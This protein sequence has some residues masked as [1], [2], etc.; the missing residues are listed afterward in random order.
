M[1]AE[2][3]SAILGISPGT[4]V[5]GL[6]IVEA[7]KLRDMQAR[8]Y[9]DRESL[10]SLILDFIEKYQ[11]GAIAMKKAPSWLHTT[12]LRK[13]YGDIRRIADNTGIFLCEYD[14]QTLR[15]ALP[16]DHPNKQSLIRYLTQQFPELV[17]P[18]HKAANRRKPHT[19]RLFEAVA[20]AHVCEMES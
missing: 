11:V 14:T 15:D 6:A 10:K 1:N 17:I 3:E 18:Y 2:R 9:K 4:R 16:G 12:S 19:E 5:T 20:C 8:E 7:G 13:L